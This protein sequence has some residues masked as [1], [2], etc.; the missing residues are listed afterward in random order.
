MAPANSRF[1][2]LAP[3]VA[4]L[5]ASGG[6]QA[7]VAVGSA[8][9][10][11]ATVNS[12]VD[13]AVLT[14]AVGPNPYRQIE[15]ADELVDIQEVDFNWLVQG[16][17][18]KFV[19]LRTL[20]E[21]SRVRNG[22][23]LWE[24]PGIED[25]LCNPDARPVLSPP[26]ASMLLFKA[27]KNLRLAGQSATPFEERLWLMRGGAYALCTFALTLTPI[28]YQKAKWLLDD[29]HATGNERLA[30]SV[31]TALQGRQSKTGQ[32][33]RVLSCVR[34][35]LL[36]ACARLDLPPLIRGVG[37]PFEYTYARRTFRDAETLM[38]A[39]RTANA[40]LAADY[41]LRFMNV[42]VAELS[43]T[44]LNVDRYPQW[45][46]DWKKE[47]ISNVLEIIQVD[48]GLIDE[49]TA[50]LADIGRILET[51]YKRAASAIQ[52]IRDVSL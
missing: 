15:V 14:S 13:I 52:S 33:A 42:I 1:L 7:V 11:R 29:L 24:R 25:L 28:G 20:R 6:T 16:V 45:A 47:A 4:A 32:L 51:D 43:G 5:C 31:F 44:F 23:F 9:A 36:M 35:A 50:D 10:R 21:I 49:L 2:K 8:V 38:Q 17:E 39:G 41:S 18:S 26:D 30:N 19:D 3:L 48:A 12:D 34:Q 37:V 22:V 40:Y 27:S 46:I